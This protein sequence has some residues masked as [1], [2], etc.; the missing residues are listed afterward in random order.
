MQH[1]TSFL[2]RSTNM[3]GFAGTLAQ[4]YLEKNPLAALQAFAIAAGWEQ[5][6]FM[7]RHFL[8]RGLVSTTAVAHERNRIVSDM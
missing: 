4:A 1:M 3:S 8:G 5:T 6:S 2:L 7:K